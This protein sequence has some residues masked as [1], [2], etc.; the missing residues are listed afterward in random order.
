MVFNS[1]SIKLGFQ[2]S[3]R[4]LSPPLLHWWVKDSANETSEPQWWKT[5]PSLFLQ[6]SSGLFS[7]A[8]YMTLFTVIRE[9]ELAAV[10]MENTRH[11]RGEMT[12]LD[13]WLDKR[14][15]TS[16]QETLKIFQKLSVWQR[17]RHTLEQTPPEW[18][19]GSSVA[20]QCQLMLAS[21]P[22]ATTSRVCQTEQ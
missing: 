1:T 7:P 8:D 3:I 18:R 12:R 4:S 5:P 11:C 6:Q 21:G 14:L 15:H 10:S 9:R 19:F 17:R 2:P 13:K 20:C 22:P 16:G